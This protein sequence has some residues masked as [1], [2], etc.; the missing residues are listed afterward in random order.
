MDMNKYME[1]K[2]QTRCACR[3][4][5]PLP[6]MKLFAR[7]KG[8]ENGGVIVLFA[9]ALPI[10]VGMISLALDVGLWYS[11]KRSLQS[12]ADTA[13]ISAAYE[14]SSAGTAADITNAALADA[15][16]NGF[17]PATGTITVN[18]PPITGPNTTKDNAVE[19]NLDITNAMLFVNAIFN[20]DITISARAV[21]IAG[22]TSDACMLSLNTS[23]QKALEISGN[24]AINTSGC[25][26]ASNSTDPSS[27]EI[28][29]STTITAESLSTAG[30]YTTK[31]A[32]ILNTT[33]APQTN[34]SPIND[35]YADLNVPAYSGCDQSEYKSAPSTTVTITPSSPTNP[36]VFCKGLDVKGTLDL[37]PGV[38]IIDGGTFNLNASA[39]LTGD[40]VTIIMTSSSGGGY[41]KFTMNG[42]ATVDLSA[43]SSGTYSG[44]LIYGDRNGPNQVNTLNGGAAGTFNGAIYVPSS[45]LEFAGN[46]SVGGSACTQLIADTIKITGATGIT[47]SGCVAA[48]ATLAVTSGAKLI[49]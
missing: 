8:D 45:I 20:M 18:N 9:F 34:A 43:P 28:S 13:A 36:Y 48:G 16:R 23:V 17:N 32:A 6:L 38:Y 11:A 27:I 41:A 5:R 1:T 12:A 3:F 31:G 37:D 49:E 4:M 30:D 33:T 44:M 25:I 46:S 15:T 47:T 21:A 40:D 24:S 26:L 22:G 19:I 42:G 39:V 2:Q 29:G 14:I 7:F 35:P 10:L